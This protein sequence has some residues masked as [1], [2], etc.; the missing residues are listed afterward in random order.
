M[1]KKKYALSLHANQVI[2]L[3]FCWFF[4]E[5]AN[6]KCHLIISRTEGYAESTP[7]YVGIVNRLFWK[8]QENF[9]KVLIINLTF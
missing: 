6:F 4:S 8:L 5:D 1:V 7:N 3:F 9:R 2:L